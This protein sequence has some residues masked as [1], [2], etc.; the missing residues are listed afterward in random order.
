P[1]RAGLVAGIDEGAHGLPA[2]AE[3]LARDAVVDVE[4]S[5]FHAADG[6]EEG[7][8][9]EP[10]LRALL[11]P[12]DSP[13]SETVR[14][15]H[16]VLVHLARLRDPRRDVAFPRLLEVVLAERAPVAQARRSLVAE[17]ER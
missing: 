16:V 11:P 12:A 15:R 9:L 2:A 10:L 4:R 13:A 6:T 3:E 5:R 17:L 7:A 1:A 14:E 8:V